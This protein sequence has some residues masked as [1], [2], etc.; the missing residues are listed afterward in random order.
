MFTFSE[1]VREIPTKFHQDFEEKYQFSCFFRENL[2]EQ[3][4]Q[5][6][7]KLLNDKIVTTFFAEILRSERCKSMKIL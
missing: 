1:D 5:I 6:F 3:I 4:I 2:N 7:K